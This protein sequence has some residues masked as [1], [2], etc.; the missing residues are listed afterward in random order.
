MKTLTLVLA[1][2]ALT[3]CATCREHPALCAAGAA[4]AITSLALSQ[5]HDSGRAH[6]VTLQP[7]NCTNGSCK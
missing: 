4:I 6:D 5:H 2:L 7:V 1:V 3:G